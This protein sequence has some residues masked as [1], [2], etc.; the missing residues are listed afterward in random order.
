MAKLLTDINKQIRSDFN[1]IIEAKLKGKNKELSDLQ[2]KN[3]D[4]EKEIQSLNNKIQK[5]N[6]LIEEN[7]KEIDNLEQQTKDFNN[8]EFERYNKLQKEKNEIEKKTQ[9]K[10]KEKDEKINSIYMTRALGPILT[11]ELF[12]EVIN[13]ARSKLKKEPERSDYCIFNDFFGILDK[14]LQTK[15][16]ICEREI[17]P[18]IEQMINQQKRRALYVDENEIFSRISTDM[19]DFKEKHEDIIKY[20]ET[21][22]VEIAEMLNNKKK[23]DEE[24]KTI[25]SAA[26]R[27]N[28][29]ELMKKLD[30]LRKKNRKLEEE[31]ETLNRDIQLKQNEIE[32][33]KKDIDTLISEI[34]DPEVAKE[35]KQYEIK[36]NFVELCKKISSTLQKRFDILLTEHVAKMMTEYFKKIDWEGKYWRGFKIDE[37]WRLLFVNEVGQT[38][39]LA[40]EAQKKIIMISFICALID[41][42]KIKI[43][44]IIDNVLSDLSGENVR[45]L[46][47]HACGNQ[48]FPQQFFFFTEDEWN[49]IRPFIEGKILQKFVFNKLSSDRTELMEES[50]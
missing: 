27:S 2:Q 25:N 16:C 9:S 8:A 23:I 28:M 31:I 3:K 43:P 24:L 29:K 21:L 36:L 35:K 11:S 7:N 47:L 48:D 18:E 26:F 6:G 30:E 14:M 46:A 42:R 40:S 39:T 15:K 33:N 12:T 32:N 5:N 13:E 44:W 45:G 17:T 19:D 50:V 22:N 4:L 37:N 1:S 34:N 20:T 41:I 49:R 38:I 10:N